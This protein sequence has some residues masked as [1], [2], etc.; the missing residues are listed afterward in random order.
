MVTDTLQ[1]F[2]NLLGQKTRNN[3]HLNEEGS[4]CLCVEDDLDIIMEAHEGLNSIFFFTR[5][6]S[7]AGIKNLD[8]VLM[9]AL[10]LNFLGLGTGGCTLGRDTV[11]N[12]LVLSVTK[13]V[14][15]LNCENFIDFFNSFIVISK[16]V[17]ASLNK[18]SADQTKGTH[19]THVS[20]GGIR[21]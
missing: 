10:D 12:T 1:T 16:K 18:D 15:E 19:E 4:I 20:D 8:Q 3:F 21:I 7:L 9:S 11:E 13:T 5:V 14:T 17:R 6:I 2:L